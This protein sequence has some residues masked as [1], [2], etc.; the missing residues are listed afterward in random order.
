MNERGS[1][2]CAGSQLWVANRRVSMPKVEGDKTDR[3]SSQEEISSTDGVL[4]MLPILISK[5]L[6]SS[7]PPVSVPEVLG[8]QNRWRG[9]KNE[10]HCQGSFLLCKIRECVLNYLFQLQHPGF[11]H[12]LQSSG[13]RARGRSEDKKPLEAGVCASVVAGTAAV[14]LSICSAEGW[15]ILASLFSPEN[16]P[17]CASLVSAF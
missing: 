5:F 11:Q 7:D 9:M 8:L 16:I 1:A 6:A 15:H 3:R 14:V 17:P 12:Y 13:R 2:S 10:E 4:A